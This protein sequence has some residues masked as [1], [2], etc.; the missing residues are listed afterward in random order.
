LTASDVLLFASRTDGM[1]GM[2]ATVIEAGMVGTP[3]AGYA[4]AGVPEVV[5]DGVT[6]FLVPPG[7]VD[8]LTERVVQLLGDE[9]RRKA[10]GESARERCLAHFEIQTVA[11]RYISLYEQVVGP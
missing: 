9:K 6:G 2:P 4:V 7:D 5:V 1:E 10:I 8:G 3:V 11:P